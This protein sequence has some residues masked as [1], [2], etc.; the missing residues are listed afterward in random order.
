MQFLSKSMHFLS[1]AKKRTP[2]VTLGSANKKGTSC[3]QA[4]AVIYRQPH[5]PL[6]YRKNP[7]CQS[8]LG[9]GGLGEE[10]L[11]F[12]KAPPPPQ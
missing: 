6:Q 9:E 3:P 2:A 1:N 8:F 10:G 4:V 7:L 5:Q 12:K 11:F